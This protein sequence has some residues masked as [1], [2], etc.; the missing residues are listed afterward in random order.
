MFC[1]EC[2]LMIVMLAIMV[3]S[4]PFIV[5]AVFKEL[6]SPSEGGISIGGE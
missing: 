1:T 2:V 6:T 4:A 5:V 3:I